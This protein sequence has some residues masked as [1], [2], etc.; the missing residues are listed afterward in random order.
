MYIEYILKDRAKDPDLIP[1]RSYYLSQIQKYWHNENIYW[2]GL[3]ALILHDHPESSKPVNSKLIA[4]SLRQRAIVHEELG[5]YWKN[6]WSCYWY[7]AP[8]ESQAL[9]IEL[10]HDVENDFTTVD[11]LKIWLLKINKPHIGI[12]QKL[13]HLL[14]MRSLPLVK[15]ISMKQKK[16]RLK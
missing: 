8:V 5:M 1:I 14:F 2:E 15:I 7:Q 16:L 6:T 4:E 9:M 10:F 11:Q 3:C 12:Q 13:R